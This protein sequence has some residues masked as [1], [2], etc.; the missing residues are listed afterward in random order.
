MPNIDTVSVVRPAARPKALV[1]PTALPLVLPA[2]SARVAD[3]EAPIAGLTSFLRN[4]YPALLLATLA[5][6]LLAYL[7]TGTQTPIFRATAVLE[8]QDLNENFLNL[9]DVS[10]VS[11]KDHA[12]L[13][14]DLPTQLRLL[15]SRSLLERVLADLPAEKVP[16]PAGLATL[17]SRRNPLP[18]PS[19]IARLEAAEQRLQVRDAKLTR[20]VDLAFESPDPAYASAF[21]NRLAQQYISQSIESRI[22]IS[23]GTSLWLER[24]MRE[25]RGKL[26]ESEGRLQ[27]YARSS[28]LVG[29]TETQRPDEEKLRQI[30]ETLSKAQENRAIRQARME[31]AIAAP[32][33]SIEPPLGSSLRDHQL[34]LADLRRQ[35]AD[36]ITVFTPN[37]DGVKRLDAQIASL[38]T[39]QRNENA[40][41]LQ[42]IRNDYSDAVRR[43]ALLQDSYHQ[44]VGQ[45]TK[46]G[47]IAIQYGI[48][49][50]EVDTNRQ[51]YNTL[52]QRAAQAKVASA[53]RASG[54]RL[55]DP[56]SVPARPSRPNRLLN[57]LWGASAGLLLGLVFVTARDRAD[58][59]IHQ[60]HHL[61]FHL[62]VPQLGSIPR[63]L[64]LPLPPHERLGARAGIVRVTPPADHLG[65]PHDRFTNAA[66]ATWL[67]RNSAEAEAY[68]AVLTS[69]LFSQAA[70]RV[71]Q[72]IVVTSAQPGDGK[73]TLVTNLAA[74]LAHMN[75]TVLL[76]DASP[77]RDLHR[78][79]GVTDNYGLS[80][81][82]DLPEIN[83]AC[84]L[85][86]L[87][88]PR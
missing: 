78:V 62:P 29:M 15:Q 64:A 86:L 79:F 7:Y 72:V 11:V 8:I 48:L 49:K 25:L 54:A 53:L 41:L 21:V 59:R 35:R 47:E 81:L 67:R 63:F 77:E 68:R 43:E 42:A 24:Q 65:D 73:T 34:K 19:L 14:S 70:G 6:I 58:R 13:G 85:M 20:I 40:S 16:A 26:A 87:T 33:E 84:W 45:V 88:P 5:G 51:L 82:I 38:E 61:A 18:P 44:Q 52:M 12:N 23:Q 37:F 76:V 10:Q 60:P 36:L 2:R 39:A 55:V 17:L 57:L 56:A 1:P 31:T 27:T 3:E 28:G 80:D 4:H 74:A 32:I 30:Q 75:R 66:L 22:E 9:G 83:P 71:P 46:Q 50:R 69:I